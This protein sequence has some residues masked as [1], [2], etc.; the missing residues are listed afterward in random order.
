[1]I[2]VVSTITSPILPP[3]AVGLGTGQSE[4]L[5]TAFLT[6]LPST[7]ELELQSTFPPK[8]AERS[9][10]VRSVDC[11]TTLRGFEPRVNNLLVVWPQANEF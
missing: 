8:D 11:G 10:V 6:C 1:M 9:G 5:G 3:I 7:L 2:L 4:S